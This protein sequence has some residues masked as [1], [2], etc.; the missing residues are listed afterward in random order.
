MSQRQHLKREIADPTQRRCNLVEQRWKNRPHDAPAWT[1]IMIQSSHFK[2]DEL[3]VRTC[4][5]VPPVCAW[6]DYVMITHRAESLG[7][8][9]I[10]TRHNGLARGRVWGA[11]VAPWHGHARAHPRVWTWQRPWAWPLLPEGEQEQIVSG[12]A[13]IVVPLACGGVACP[14][15]SLPPGTP[16]Q[17]LGAATGMGEAARER[18][19]SRRNPVGVASAPGHQRSHGWS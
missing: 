14:E 12:N 17:A 2:A 10:P 3:L 15:A 7:T 1:S 11:V 8:L 9:S 4:A 5:E 13:A 16:H 18:R 19:G 6:P